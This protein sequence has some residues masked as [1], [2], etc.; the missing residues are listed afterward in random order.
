MRKATFSTAVFADSLE[1]VGVSSLRNSNSFY[2]FVVVVVVC[3]PAT[4]STIP[5]RFEYNI[6][7]T[8]ATTPIYYL[9][10]YNIDFP[11]DTPTIASN[12]ET[13]E[14]T[15]SFF[16]PCWY[17]INSLTLKCIRLYTRM[18]TNCSLLTWLYFYWFLCLCTRRAYE[19]QASSRFIPHV[20]IF[21]YRWPKESRRKKQKIQHTADG[22]MW[23]NV[24]RS[25][26]YDGALI[27]YLGFLA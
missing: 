25:S 17:T 20:Y 22:L 3:C 12:F 24:R 15:W 16:F 10:V 11:V 21:I 9:H 5:S 18:Y 2:V 27:L 19:V 1:D 8:H 7:L 6:P 14:G 26:S 13:E 4:S 23:D